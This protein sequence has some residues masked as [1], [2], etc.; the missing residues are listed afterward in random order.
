MRHLCVREIMT[1]TDLCERPPGAS[2]RDACRAMAEQPCGSVLITERGKL[3]GIF[4]E[5]DLVRR[6]LAPG[7]DP[8][9]TLLVEVMTREPGTIRPDAR[10]DEAI[11]KMDGFGCRHLPVVEHGRVV[12]VV[13]LRDLSIEDLA[14]MHA[15]L[16][17]RRLVAE[18]AW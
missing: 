4:T 9:L 6:V 18:R 15:E 2:V 13:S 7:L 17:M 12:G 5:S 8:R 14:A 16:E 11:R 10:V 3:L 1:A